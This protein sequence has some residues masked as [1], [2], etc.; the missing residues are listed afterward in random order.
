M[1]TVDQT[2]FAAPDR[3]DGNDADGVPGNCWQACVAS[4]LEL[5][6]DT[7]PHFILAD[8]W[9]EVTQAYVAAV[10]PGWEL[11]C[12][13]GSMDFPLYQFPDKAPTHAIG[14]G[15]SPRGDFMHAVILDART[16]ELAHDPHPSRAGLA[17]IV[18]EVMALAER[19]L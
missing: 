9:W 8:D 4:L 3:T 13:D 5:P 6:L 19:T 16:G 2:I 12:F 7:V 14:S 11:L 18:V 1:L 17:G 15:P 10:K